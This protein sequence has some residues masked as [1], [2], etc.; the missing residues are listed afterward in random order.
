MNREQIIEILKEV[1]THAITSELN[2]DELDDEGFE[3]F[4]DRLEQ[5]PEVSDEEIEENIPNPEP[6]TAWASAENVG[7]RKGVKWLQ[8]HHPQ[9]ISEEEIE[10]VLKRYTTKPGLIKTIVALLDQN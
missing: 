6:P 2:P 10:E 8:S 9:P 5:Q 3:I 1:A 7:F 4:A